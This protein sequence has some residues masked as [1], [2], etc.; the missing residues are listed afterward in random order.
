MKETCKKTLVSVISNPNVTLKLDQAH[1]NWYQMGSPREVFITKRLT[2][3]PQQLLTKKAA[4]NFLVE[5][6]SNF[7]KSENTG[8]TAEF[9]REILYV[10]FFISNM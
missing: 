5:S 8:I 9:I 1:P 7:I 10:M 4:I 2:I 6:G 3:P